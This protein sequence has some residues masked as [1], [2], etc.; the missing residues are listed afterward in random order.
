MQ[1]LFT[2]GTLAP[3]SPVAA[4]RDGWL[5]DAVRGRLYDLGPYPALV[6]HD[7]P[8][9]GWVEGFVRTVSLDRLK[10]CLDSYEG[11]CEGL[12]RRVL[13]PSRGGRQV[14][15][16]VYARPLPPEAVGPLFRWDSSKRVG[17]LG[18]PALFQGGD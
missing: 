4:L 2:Y 9:A 8:A 5:A 3:E 10:G 12:Y 15:V 17:I 14:W 13:A 6:D 1:L 11:V 18:P 16:Y 7:D